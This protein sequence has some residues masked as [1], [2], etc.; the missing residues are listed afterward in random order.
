MDIIEG[1]KRGERRRLGKWWENKDETGWEEHLQET[2]RDVGGKKEEVK[3]PAIQRVGGLLFSLLCV[4]KAGQEGSV[5]VRTSKLHSLCQSHYR[6]IVLHQPLFL[7]VVLSHHHCLWTLRWWAQ[8]PDDT[9]GNTT[10]H[11]H[12]YTEKQRGKAEKHSSNDRDMCDSAWE[13]F[14]L[15][16]LVQPQ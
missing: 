14:W 16:P 2:F 3:T 9:H 5:P 15:P 4:D 1:K 8:G 10:S 12:L 13:C 7:A 6:C 11:T